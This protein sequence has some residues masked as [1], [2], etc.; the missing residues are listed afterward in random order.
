MAAPYNPPKKGEDFIIRIGLEDMAN[1]GTFRVSPTIA[2]GDFQ[3]DKDGG[4]FA[5]LSTLPTVDPTGTAAVKLTLSAT[6]MNADVVT[7]KGVDQTVPK[8]WADFMI[9]IPTTQ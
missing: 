6:E 4:G 1:P 2:A 3:V 7:V 9:S 8:E 5:D